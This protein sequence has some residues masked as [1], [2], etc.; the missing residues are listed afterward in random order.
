MVDILQMMKKAQELQ[1]RMGE[2]QE[3]LGELTVEG[4]SGGGLVTV[5]LSGKFELKGIKID[6]SLMKAGEE[7]ILED[8]ILA[9]HADAKGKA[10]TEAAR[11]MQE[12]TAGLPLP[13][14]MKLPF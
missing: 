1:N 6:P 3:K 2:V 9:A 14:G 8:L 12:V 5:S 4:R 10:E 11:Q 7:G 13:P